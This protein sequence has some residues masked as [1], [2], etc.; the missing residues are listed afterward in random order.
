MQPSPEVVSDTVTVYVPTRNRAALALR[1]IDSV[2]AQTHPGVELVVVNDASSEGGYDEV[3]ARTEALGGRYLEHAEP[4]GACAA[5]NRAIEVATGR[6]VTGLD[7]DDEFLPERLAELVARFDPDTMAFVASG[8]LERSAAGTARRTYCSGRIGAER[9]LH[10]NAVG[11]QVLTLTER[12]RALGGFDVRYPAMQDHELWLR[13]ALEYGD[14]LKIPSCSYVLHRDH[15]G[16][17]IGG[18]PRRFRD[19][20][21]LFGRTHG[22]RFERRHRETHELLA[23]RS[24]GR[25]ASFWAILARMNR[26]NAKLALSILRE[27]A[28]A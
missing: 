25:E 14:G 22:H 8:Y 23:L 6:F 11:N 15:G 1:A 26:A 27:R 7:D 19:A 18:D 16:E 21:A 24:A 5:R 20:Q 10:F 12:L 13:L 28:R 9:L 3:R 4:L 17:R 2:A